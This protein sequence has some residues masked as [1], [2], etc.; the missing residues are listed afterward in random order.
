MT[1]SV[2]T[3]GRAEII[4]VVPCYNEAK[5]LDAPTFAEFAHRH[6]NI[7]VL[8]VDDGSTDD[9]PLILERLRQQHSSRVCTLRLSA[10]VGKAEAV[11]RGMRI[12]LR[13]GPLMVG[14][15][16]SDL[17][18]PLESILSFADLLRARP[19]FDLVMGSR[20]ALLGR[21]IQRNGVRHFAGRVFATIASLVLRLPVYDTQCGAKLFRVTPS[22]AEVISRPFR[23]RW[24]FDVEILARLLSSRQRCGANCDRNFIYEY[25]LEK[26]CDVQNSRLKPID[27][28]IAAIDLLAIS[29]EYRFRSG[30]PQ[31][32]ANQTENERGFPDIPDQRA[33]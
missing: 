29:R 22:F 21:D 3:H 33:A 19:N 4:V 10:N 27:F 13:R 25:P 18:T 1:E 31:A 14:Y 20:V 5:R 2:Q 32:I 16:D 24:I 17:A 23:S 30:V 12:A 9:T 6:P 28:A 8:F 7:T 11:R 26:W 15:W